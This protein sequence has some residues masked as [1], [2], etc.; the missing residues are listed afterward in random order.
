MDEL[1]RGITYSFIAKKNKDTI[2][3]DI[4]LSYFIISQ[5][6]HIEEYRQQKNDKKNAFS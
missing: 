6:Y 2:D 1:A 5:Y 3:D 4:C